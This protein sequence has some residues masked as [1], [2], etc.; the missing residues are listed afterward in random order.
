MKLIHMKTLTIIIMVKVVI[1]NFEGS[2]NKIEAKDLSIVNVSL[3]FI[4]IK[5][6]HYYKIVL[7]MATVI[8]PVFWETIQMAIE[9]Q[10]MAVDLTNSEDVV[11]AGPTI[12]ITTECISISIT[13]M[14]HNHNNT[15]LPAVYVADLTI[16]LSIVIRENMT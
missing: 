12:R 13:H 11:V 4:T 15:V 16:L 10:A 14:T 2:Y 1:N 3:N 5:E 7:N 6:M 9:A 8:N